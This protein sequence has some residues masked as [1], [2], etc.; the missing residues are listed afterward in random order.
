MKTY[1]VRL[2]PAALEDLDEAYRRSAEN[3]PET[4]FRWFNRFFDSL[5][6]LAQHPS[7]CMIAAED[8]N[9]KR[10]LRQL[11]LRQTTSCLPR[12]FHR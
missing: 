11:A 1:R 10:E 9:S 12:H 7:R 6:T 8:R 2:Q 3:A 5:Q 4:A